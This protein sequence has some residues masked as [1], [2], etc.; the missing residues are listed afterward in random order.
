MKK[1]T[2]IIIALF[3]VATIFAQQRVVSSFKQLDVNM[4][5]HKTPQGLYPASIADTVCGNHPLYYTLGTG[6]YVLGTNTYGDLEKAQKYSAP[7]G[8]WNVLGAL[9]LCFSPTPTSTAAT[10]IKIYSVNSIYPVAVLGTSQPIQIQNFETFP[11]LTEYTF[12][13]P[14]ALTTT[15]FMVSYVLP[16]SDTAVLLSTSKNITACTSHITDSL[17]WELWSDG[18][19]WKSIEKAW[20][21]GGVGL[22]TDIYIFPVIDAVSGINQDLTINGV[23]IGQNYPNPAIGNTT[24]KYQLSQYT[25]NVTINII[26]NNGKVVKAFNEGNKSAGDY[27]ISFNA[28]DLPCGMYYYTI[29][30]NENRFARKMI[31][32]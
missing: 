28:D 11:D 20:S 23:T 1:F 18:T 15:K 32:E 9:V 13:T 30:T 21:S 16:T 10:S 7:T 24:I 14:V 29:N 31:V 2:L 19:T 12:T 27:S 26:D 5:D 4:T 8:T 17:S 22:K 25:D 3:A 6:G